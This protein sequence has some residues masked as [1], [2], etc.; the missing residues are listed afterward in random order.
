MSPLKLEG[1]LICI[2]ASITNGEGVKPA[3]C[4]VGLLKAKAKAE[5][6]HLE[7]IGQ[8][9]SGWSTGAYVHNGAKVVEAMP[10]DATIVT[11]LLGTNDS[12]EDGSP[13][14]IGERAAENLAK[15][16]DLYQE[17]AP[18]AQFIVVGPTKCY[19]EILTKR[20]L[21]AHYGKKTP[22]NLHAISKGFAAVARERGLRFIDLS[23][24]PSSA[25]DSIDGIHVKAAGH[26]QIFEAIWGCLSAAEPTTKP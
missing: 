24:V 6:L 22:A 20:L 1:K 2:G 17:K 9:R 18:H 4:Y 13:E 7:V 14:E 23:E 16:I 15:L 10:M 12:R 11:I 21:A 3:E 25:N 5:N 19:P 8:G 26:L